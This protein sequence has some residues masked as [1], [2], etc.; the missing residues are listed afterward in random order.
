MSEINK[1]HGAGGSATSALIDEIFKKRFS[2]EYLKPLS[3]SAHVPGYGRLA[4]TTDSFVVRPVFFPGGDIGRLAVCGTVNDILMSGARPVYLTAGFILEEGLETGDLQRIVD[5]MA[6]TAVEAGV[7]IVAGDT[8]VIEPADPKEPGLIIN[9][10]GVGF[11]DVGIETGTGQIREG[12]AVIVSGELGDHHAAILSCRLLVKNNIVSDAAPLNDMVLGLIREGINI[13]AMR[14][15]TR[16][17][18]ATI[19]NEL[20]G[21]SGRH[22]RIDE[23]KLP[24]S[25]EVTEFSKLL[26]LDPMYMG[27]EGKCVFILPQEEV[28]KALEIIRRSRYGSGAVIAGSVTSGAAG[29]TIRTAIGGERTAEPL[30]GEGLPRIC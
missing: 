17:G 28:D 10:S 1:T 2:N 6:E 15:I 29:V 23:T 22:I 20:S 30:R 26:G 14:D 16:G 18:L 21:S 12:D 9:T 8:K 25:F 4:L 11:F 24:V 19:L 7:R 3:D 27:N 13:H 5:S